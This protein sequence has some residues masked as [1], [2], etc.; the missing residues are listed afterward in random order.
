MT[1]SRQRQIP[2]PPELFPAVGRTGG[3]TA[4]QAPPQRQQLPTVA[5]AGRQGRLSPAQENEAAK[6]FRDVMVSGLSKRLN[7]P[8][9]NF[10]GWSNDQLWQTAQALGAGAGDAASPAASAA[11]RHRA[12]L[13]GTGRHGHLSVPPRLFPASK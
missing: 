12:G 8:V 11:A 3:G 7:M 10:S 1:V 9:G 5:I 6:W 2:R 4:P 13:N